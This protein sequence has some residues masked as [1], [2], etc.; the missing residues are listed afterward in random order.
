MVQAA[1]S[2]ASTWERPTAPWRI[3]PREDAA[4]A[5]QTF[6]APRVVGLNDVADRS[7]LPSFLYLPADKEFP[8]GSLDLPWKKK[9][10]R[11]VGDF[12]RDHGAK[13][14]GRLVGSAKSWLSHSGVDRRADF[15]LGIARRFRQSLAGGSFCKLLNSSARRLEP[16]NRRENGRRSL[17]TSRRFAYRA[18][19]FRR[20]RSRVDRRG[21]A[22]G[23]LGEHYPLGGASSRVLFVARRARRTL[24]QK[25]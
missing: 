25:R 5:I 20:R 12:A 2:S 24:A 6:L 1:T 3:P 18:R 10:D 19:R 8:P 13:V 11:A 23:R 14:P 17:G 4:G 16:P 22:I 7:V 15:T 9:G 21:R